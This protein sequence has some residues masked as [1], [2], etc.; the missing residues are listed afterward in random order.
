MMGKFE[1]IKRRKIILYFTNG[2]NSESRATGDGIEIL[3]V[4]DFLGVLWSG[5]LF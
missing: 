2:A 5:S 4:Q 1:A 3:N